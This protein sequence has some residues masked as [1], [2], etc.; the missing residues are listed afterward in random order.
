MRILRTIVIASCLLASFQAAAQESMMDDVKKLSARYP[1][2]WQ[3]YETRLSPRKDGSVRKET[4]YD[5][6]ISRSVLTAAEQQQLTTLCQREWQRRNPTGDKSLLYVN[7]DSVSCTIA[8][9][10]PQNSD[11]SFAQSFYTRKG[12][13]LYDQGRSS[14]T[15][16]VSKVDIYAASLQQP[17]FTAVRQCISRLVDSRGATATDVRYSGANGYFCFM[18]GDGKGWTTGTRYTI[19]NPSEGDF[20]DVKRAFTACATGRNSVELIAYNDNI[21]LHNE[22]GMEIF[23]AKTDAKGRLHLLCATEGEEPCVPVDWPTID[24]FNNGI[25][26]Y[27]DVSRLE[28]ISEA[29]ASRPGGVHTA[30]RYTGGWKDGCP[31]FE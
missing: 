21:I 6:R 12:F 22:A 18:R 30:V 26:E 20:N 10:V 2:A 24:F 17:D 28:S 25:T 29:L 3:R 11:L 19:A 7:G 13:M 4:R 16:R 27:V 1:N 15:V 8:Y 23:M 9:G 31:G 5:L 14:F